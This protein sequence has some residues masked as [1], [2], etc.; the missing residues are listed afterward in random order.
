[1]LKIV[2]D[3]DPIW[4]VDNFDVL[5]I[6]TS[7]YNQLNGGF[8]S[9]VKY[10]Y[11]IV[12]EENNKTKYAYTSKLGTRLTIYGRPTIS[13]MYVCG[14]PRP[15]TETVNYEA[16][17]RC[18]RTANAEFK[19]KKVITT[20][21]GASPFDGNGNKDRCLEI[22]EESTSDLEIWVYDYK[23]KKRK[24]EIEEQRCYLKSLQ[25]TNEDKYNKL[26]AVFDLYLKKLYLN[27]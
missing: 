17:E 5:L 25:H 13:L 7:T 3:K 21:V 16:L 8:Q 2:K 14:Y 6:G 10:K 19:G 11:P 1:M 22:I 15:N 23:Q 27:G 9:K 4:D 12:E 20:I 24:D 18:L 26:K